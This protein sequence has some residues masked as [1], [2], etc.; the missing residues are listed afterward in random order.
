MST[1][2][3][4]MHLEFLSQLNYISAR[5]DPWRPVPC[6]QGPGGIPRSRLA[7][8]EEQRAAGHDE[9]AVRHV[10]HP[11]HR[12]DITGRRQASPHRQERGP[13]R[14]GRG[15]DYVQVVLALI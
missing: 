15:G 14:A 3:K 4:S 7:R 9:A 13:H 6:Q 1:G 8:G 2:K 12:A 5:E 11:S 10:L